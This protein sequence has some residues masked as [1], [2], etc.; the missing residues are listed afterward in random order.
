MLGNIDFILVGKASLGQNMGKLK[1]A[2]ARSTHKILKSQK[3][4]AV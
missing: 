3:L 4:F 1:E 2:N